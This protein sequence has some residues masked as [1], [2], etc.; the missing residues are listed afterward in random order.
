MAV[1]TAFTLTAP[2]T[3]PDAAW[4][5]LVAHP[6]LVWGHHA[7]D[8]EPGRDYAALSQVGT[9]GE[10]RIEAVQPGR[11]EFSW[12]GPGWEQPGR[13]VLFVGQELRVDAHAVPET[14]A[15][16]ARAHWQRM[17]AVAADYLNH[18][19]PPL[20]GPVRAVLFDAD[21]VLQT[22][23]PGWLADFTRIGGQDFVVDAFRAEVEYL[24]GGGDLKPRL[25]ELLAAS[26]TGG[27]VEEI[28]EVWHDIVMDAEALAV[29][30]RV[31]A[32]GVIVGLATNQ[33]SYRGGHMRRVYGIDR[34]F[35]R[36]FY[37]YEVGHAKPSTDYFAHIVAELGL[38]AG[39][40]AFVDDAP[41]NVRGARL[42]GLRA[43]LHRASDGAAGLASD[44]AALGV[45]I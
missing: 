24:A 12:G 8:L 30:D 2:L 25:E 21:G 31:R 34:H 43:A 36:T 39:Q 20:D 23:R 28:L 38:P 14:E 4:G 7:P 29:V 45:P 26:G 3:D 35:D 22:P 27:S 41:A 13:F 6:E 19:N 11:V 33:Q 42:A 18:P 44:L 17:I 16:A 9:G 1:M 32:S 10:G 15:D 37:S 40:V 5:E